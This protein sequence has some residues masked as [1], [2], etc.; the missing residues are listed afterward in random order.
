M[1][2]LRQG[3]N[4]NRQKLIAHS[5]INH[6]DLY[7]RFQSEFILHDRNRTGVPSLVITVL[8]RKLNA[9]SCG[10]LFDKLILNANSCGRLF[11]E[12]ILPQLLWIAQNS[13]RKKNIQLK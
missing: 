10:R 8:G 9:N 4:R 11:D 5:F 6:K 1:S 12:L 7:E 2:T 13:I 3:S